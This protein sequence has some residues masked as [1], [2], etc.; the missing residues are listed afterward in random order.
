ML[1]SAIHIIVERIVLH[2]LAK[3]PVSLIYPGQV[4]KYNPNIMK[5]NR[6]HIQDG[7]KNGSIYDLTITTNDVVKR[8]DIATFKRKVV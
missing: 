6:V 5:R 1:N 8:G 4:T 3:S 2:P 7:T